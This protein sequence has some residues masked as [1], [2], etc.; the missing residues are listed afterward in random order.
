MNITP[1]LLRKLKALADNP[2]ATDGE[3]AV[4]QQKLQALAEQAGID[5][6]LLDQEEEETHYWLGSLKSY[7]VQLAH[8][9][10]FHV[11]QKS[12]I[13]AAYVKQRGQPRRYVYY[14][15][16]RAHIQFQLLFPHYLKSF[17]RSLKDYIEAFI[18]VNNLFGPSA[19]KT[20]DLSP[21]DLERLFRIA[22]MAQGIQPTSRPGPRLGSGK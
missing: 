8:Q 19:G 1:E 13:R 6:S 4:A 3:R 15:T 2:G 16:Y 21:A 11:A 9:V 14:S 18:N 5:L 10:L 17:R 22:K 12:K 7:E 20:K